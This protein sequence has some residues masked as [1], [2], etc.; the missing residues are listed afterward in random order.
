MTWKKKLMK[1]APLAVCGII[2][3]LLFA[4]DASAHGYIDNG[5]SSLC[6]QGLNKGCGPIQ[7]EPQ[8]VEG[9][10]NFPQAGPADGQ[11]AGGG[12]YP[13]LDVQTATRWHKVNMTG[14]K[15]TFAWTLTA[16]H[17]TAEWKYYITKKGWDPNKPLTR[18]DLELITTFDGGNKQPSKTTTHVIDVPTDRTGYHIILGVW[19]IADTPNA[20]YQV[21]DVNLQNEGPVQ[22]DTVAPSVPTNVAS[23]SQTPTSIDLTW[24]AATDNI[25]VHHYDLYRNGVKVQTV[26]GTTTT[27]NGL[28]ANTAY[29]YTVKAVD[30]A[31]NTSNE[32]APITVKTKELP[33][34]DTVAPS[35]PT[36][37]HSMGE[38]ETTIDLMWNAATDNVGVKQYDIYRN[39]VKVK[40]VTGTMTTDTGLQANTEYTYTVKAVDAAGNVSEVSNTF[41]V[42]TK[43]KPTTPGVAEWDRS[44]VYTKGDRVLFNGLEY[45]AKWWTQGNEPATSDAWKLVSQTLTVEWN[46]N[47]SYVGGERVVFNGMKYEA[48]WWTQGEVPGTTSVWKQV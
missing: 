23:A 9:L 36:S 26:T 27:D 7:Y 20:F 46:A 2:G 30:S 19:E 14:G 35:A 16:A 10:G 21:V 38:T 6:K 15:N 32:S 8:S 5:R 1:V 17:S 13:D 12:H 40:T 28:T 33:A 3:S 37:L 34:V 45:E 29:T 4:N 43:E 42:K 25:G 24:N 31:G 11:I 22:P 39:G 18:A 44:K 48:K 41:V 47:K